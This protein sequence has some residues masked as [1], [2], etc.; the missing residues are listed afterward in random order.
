MKDQEEQ[1]V[2]ATGV[3]GTATVRDWIEAQFG[4]TCTRGSVYTLLA[5]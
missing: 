1:V 3:F 5:R 2:A 4:V